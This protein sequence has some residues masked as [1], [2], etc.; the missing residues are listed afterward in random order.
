MSF[1]NTRVE[2]P[3]SPSSFQIKQDQMLHHVLFLLKPVLH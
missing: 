2:E 3:V 1:S